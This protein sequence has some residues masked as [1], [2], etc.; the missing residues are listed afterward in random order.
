MD[1]LELYRNA[2]IQ[3]LTE[4][5]N[6]YPKKETID[7]YVVVD[8]S[9]KNYFFTRVGWENNSRIHGSPIHFRIKDEKIWIEFNGTEEDLTESLVD[10]G[11]PKEDIVLGLLHPSKRQWA[12]KG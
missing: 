4:Y 9:T 10:K 1:K 6:E 8:D 3:V 2:I 7:K 5:Y 11:I 12:M